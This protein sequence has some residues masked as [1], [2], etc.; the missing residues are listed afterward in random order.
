MSSATGAS[1]G[2]WLEA[3]SI[4]AADAGAFFGAT[5][6]AGPRDGPAVSIASL[7][8]PPGVICYPMNDRCMSVSWRAACIPKDVLSYTFD[9]P[10]AALAAFFT[11][12]LSADTPVFCCLTC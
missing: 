9:L 1:G 5:F 7:S 11:G 6:N 10:F 8:D 3:G 4:M 12:E 2:R